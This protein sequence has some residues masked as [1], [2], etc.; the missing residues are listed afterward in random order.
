M[1]KKYLLFFLLFSVSVFA[2]FSKTHY[3]PPLSGSNDVSTI[4]QDQYL[5]ISTPNTS[6][7][8]FVIHQLGGT[9]ITGTVSKSTPYK[10]T[11]GTGTGT[12]L[13]VEQSLVNT[14]LN[15][16]GYI[17]EAEDLIYVSVRVIGGNNISQAGAVVSKGLAALGTRFRIGALLNTALPYPTPPAAPLYDDRDYT[18]ISVLATENNTVVQFSDIKPGA[19]LINSTAGNTPPP[20][21]LNSGESFVIAVN[22][23]NDFN[24]DALIGSLVT[25]DKPIVVNC[26]SFAG[27]NASNN[28]D[29]GFDQIVSV[30]RTGT[31]YIFI[32]STGQDIVE[33][34]LLVGDVNN[35]EIY[36]NGNIGTPNYVLNAGEYIALDGSSF[37]P[38]GNLYVRTNNKIFAYQTVGDNSRTD[39][40]NQELFFVPPL[41]CETPHI[42]DNIPKLEE[43]GNRTFQ[44][45][46]TL[47]TIAGSTLNFEV[48]GVSYTLATLTAIPG[49]AV[50]G[51]TVVPT[52]SQNYDTYTITGLTGNFSAYSTTQLYL[53]AYGTDGAATFGGFYSGFTFKPEVSFNLLAAGGNNCIPNAQLSVNSLSP[54]D[55]FQWYFNDVPIL[56]ATLSA[57]NPLQPGFYY[58]KATLASCGT[59]LISDKIPVSACP[60]NYDADLANDNIDVDNDNDGITDC[61]ESL[62]NQ[63][64][65]LT[66]SSVLN[67][68]TSGSVA[69]DPIPFSGN[70]N[71]DFVTRTPIGKDNT[72]SFTKTFALPTNISLEYVTAASG[73][74]LLNSNAQFTITGNVNKTIT[75][76]NPNNQLLID[77]NYDGIYESDIDNFSSF[78]IRFRLN[79]TIPLT[80]GTGTFK[81]KS[82]HADFIKLTHNNL[83]DADANNA[84]FK[85]ITTCVPADTDGDGVPNALDIDSDNDG[86]PDVTEA[87]GSSSIPVTNIDS[88]KDGLD[89]A[90]GFGLNPLDTDGDGVPN[91]IDLDSDN[92]GI[93]D[94]IES[95]NTTIDANHDGRIDGVSADFGS[96]GLYNILETTVDSGVLNYTIADT[97]TNGI[98]NYLALDSDND[99]CTDV[100]EASYIDTDGDGILGTAPLTYNANGLVTNAVGYGI[101]LNNNYIIYAPIT[102]TTQPN[103]PTV[104]ALQTAIM[105]IES[106]PVDSYHWQVLLGTTWTD[107]IDD[108][109]YSQSNTNM[110]HINA[111]P[112]SFNGLRFRVILQKNGNSCNLISGLGTLSLYTLPIVNSPVTLIQCDDD[113]DGATT[114]NL[115]QKESDIASVS[116]RTFTY[117]TTAI[118]AANGDE[119]SGSFINNP[120]NYFSNATS[121]WVRVVDNI[122]GCFSVA[123]L[124]VIITATQI[125][126][127]FSRKFYTCDDFLDINGNNSSSNNK[128]DGISAFDF[129]S[130]TAAI[131]ALLPT[132]TT[133]TI[134]YYKNLQ[135]A[136]MEVDPSGQSLEISQNI[137]TPNSIYNYRNREYPNQQ[138]IWVRV[139]S[140]LDNSCYGLGA[141]VTLNVESLPYA[142]PYND[143]NIIRHCDDDQDGIYAF[144]TSILQSV[145]LN[146]QTN[147][148][149]SYF[150]GAGNPL[151]SP[152]PNP[153]PVN[154]TETITV[155]VVNS[156]SQ[157][158]NGPC[159]EEET[160]QFIVDDLPQ[161]FPIDVSLITVCDDELDPL[162][163]DGQFAFD[164]SSIESSVLN[165]QTGMTIKYFDGTLHALPYPLPNPL[166]TSTQNLTVVVENPINRT[167][168]ATMLLPFVVQK[169]PKIKLTDRQL[170]CTDQP[171]FFT[172]I[173]AGLTDGSSLSNYSF[174]WYFNGTMLPSGT[175][176]SIDVT[177]SGTYTVEVTTVPQGCMRTRTVEIDASDIAHITDIIVHDLTDYNSVEVIAYGNGTLLYSLDDNVT[178]QI[179][180]VFTEV[181]SGIHQVYVK[182]DNGCGVVGPVPI[183]VLGIPTFFT[184]DGDGVN[185]TWNIKGASN[186]FNKNAIIYIF[187]RN[188][189]LIKQL[190][191]IGKGWDGTF[192]GRQLPSEDYWYNIQLEDK[193]IF[194]GHFSLTR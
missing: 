108:A 161:A 40:A 120:L 50:I 2:Q 137:L 24:R 16:K 144:N 181:T 160:I 126:N 38:Q 26:G 76:V 52:I 159:Y 166:T 63:P 81:F 182:D 153:Y 109:T 83:S 71:G 54:F 72:V 173:N 82:A 102:I 7:V 110:L 21:T 192:N 85:L 80:P 122:H 19:V 140:T 117:Y 65:D 84:T 170:I 183:Y 31:E 193:R 96:N 25:S 184:P 68:T 174:Q 12:Q 6:P 178:Y 86:I 88:N 188:G 3:I 190:S 145:I 141:Y 95:G 150:D 194:K 42:I 162:L 104:C 148:V 129:S 35:T 13:H 124:D 158:P 168:P 180:N 17:I 112:L 164:T 29:L 23:P 93:Y 78:E 46:A 132:T 138:L 92:D 48:N 90:Y 8:N 98:P 41:N 58:V 43:I 157:A 154:L 47:I 27:T 60:T 186:S 176:Y 142:Y 56:G 77:T 62:G 133:Y 5:Y 39:W 101:L 91:Y 163:Q 74:D 97:D 175:T 49:V 169:V 1:K 119:T 171:N 66:D 156:S 136:S 105:T 123:Q 135:D 51:P 191:P 111:P 55:V 70:T 73:S 75:L 30:E 28:I 67:V 146:G 4:I 32:K 125:P 185:D 79:S 89:D 20:V 128:R 116:N 57:Y 149:V 14:V 45:R 172:T 9:N 11:I 22:G 177:A 114:I 121:V 18:F 69:P 147:V 179:S 87:Q 64:I 127:S 33:R 187:D 37:N 61:N 34:V 151:L 143:T 10:F 99:G 134:K 167:C 44:G 113:N 59:T 130:V 131:A 36:L 189:K 107:I 152:L 15:N 53:A 106:T 94:L 155:R 165:G 100:L 139:D 115:R 103:A 118:G